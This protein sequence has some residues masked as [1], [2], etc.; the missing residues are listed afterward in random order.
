MPSDIPAP[1]CD[2][3]YILDGEHF[4]IESHGIVVQHM[5][6]YVSNTAD[7]WN[8][9]MVNQHCPAVVFD[10]YPNGPSTQDTTQN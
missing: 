1:S 5:M 6:K 3:Q 7:M 9:I 2:V 8:V 4:Y 10:G